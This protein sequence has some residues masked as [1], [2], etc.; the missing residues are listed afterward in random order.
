MDTTN[1]LIVFRARAHLLDYM[2]M[3][4]AS[5]HRA[6]IDQERCRI[7]TD[8]VDM[9]LRVVQSAQDGKKLAGNRYD[10]VLHDSKFVAYRGWYDEVKRLLR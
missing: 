7:Q 2:E 9:Y 8:D 3:A 5:S 4:R 1:V 10:L 6:R